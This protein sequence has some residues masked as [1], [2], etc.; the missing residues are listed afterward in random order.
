MRPNA[1][2]HAMRRDAR[3]SITSNRPCC[4]FGFVSPKP[5][6]PDSA[7]AQRKVT[8]DAG[9][10]C[11][12]KTNSPERAIQQLPPLSRRRRTRSNLGLRREPAM[13]I[14]RCDAIDGNYNVAAEPDQ[15]AAS[16]AIDQ[17]AD[18]D[19]NPFVIIALRLPTHA[20]LGHRYG[21]RRSRKN[22]AA[23]GT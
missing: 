14:N 9:L 2:N 23:S 3:M 10:G 18:F 5:K 20:A 1:Q 6:G 19:R 13:G 12:R 4:R 17:R 22:C 16:V 21:I 7:A 8:Q 11:A 15:I